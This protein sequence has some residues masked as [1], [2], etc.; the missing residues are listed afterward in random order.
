MKLFNLWETEK[1]EVHDLGLKDYI[2]IRPLMIP[3]TGGRNVRT[4]FWKSKNHIVERLMNKLMVS[5]HK[6]RKHKIS[7]GHNSGKS[8]MVY[9]AVVDAF[10]IIEKQTSNNPVEVFVKALEN[11]APREEITT[12]EYGGAKYPQS[13][14][15]SPQR[16]IDIALRQM[17]HGSYDNSFRSKRK[18]SETLADE[19][20][21][22]YNNDNKSQAIAKKMELERQAEASR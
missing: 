18:I 22:A 10:K 3:R 4:Q 16:R 13:V 15:C 5:G 7:S 9:N 17:V 11:A 19:I 1:I 2:N 12:I 20:M 8:T 14:E 6:G 21:K